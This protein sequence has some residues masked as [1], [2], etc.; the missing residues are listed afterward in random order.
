MKKFRNF[1]SCTAVAA[2]LI[3]YTIYIYRLFF[4]YLINVPQLAPLLPVLV[5]LSITLAIIVSN[6]VFISSLSMFD[7][8]ARFLLNKTE[9]NED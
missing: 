9:K 3:T 1:Y 8:I 2:V 7:Y 6:W 5:F 4:D